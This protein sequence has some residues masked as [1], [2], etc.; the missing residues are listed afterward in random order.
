MCALTL[1]V[2]LN[3]YSRPAVI[4]PN[5]SEPSIPVYQAIELVERTLSEGDF[6]LIATEWSP[7]TCPDQTRSE[8]AFYKQ[9]ITDH[10]LNLGLRGRPVEW[11]W[12]VTYAKRNSG[13][14][15]GYRKWE[16]ISFQVQSDGTVASLA[17]GN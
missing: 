6:I 16:F 13:Q 11:S 4:P 8:N 1:L 10:P 2:G 17:A 15:A 3:A 7:L 14:I 5:F 9:P 12:F